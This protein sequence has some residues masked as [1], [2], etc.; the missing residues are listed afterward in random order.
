[1]YVKA[2]T[3]EETITFKTGITLGGEGRELT[4]L[5]FGSVTPVITIR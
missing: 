1:M 5:T 2:G 4:T 3:Y